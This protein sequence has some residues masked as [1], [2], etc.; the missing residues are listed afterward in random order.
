MNLFARLGLDGSGFIRGLASAKSAAG[1]FSSDLVGSWSKDI[2]SKLTGAFGFAAV[3][4]AIAAL[5]RQTI[6][7]TD[8]VGDLSDQL[9]MTTDDIQR[10]MIA[11]GRNG[12]EFEAIAK[13]ITH[14]GDARQKALAGDNKSQQMFA[15]YGVSMKQLADGQLANFELTKALYDSASKAGIGVQ[16]QADLFDLAGK[17]GARLAATFE[18]LKNLGPVKLLS[19]ENIKDL[20]AAQDA[21]DEL[22][23]R[24]MVAAAPVAGFGARVLGRMQAPP[25]SALETLPGIGLFQRFPRALVGELFGVGK[26]PSAP[27]TEEQIAAEKKRRGSLLVAPVTSGKLTTGGSQIDTSDSYS[28]IGLFVGG[29]GNPMV[30]ISRRQLS[31]SE[32]M[33]AELRLLRAANSRVRP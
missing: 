21:I 2:G 3:T 31:V 10:A 14:I 23:R 22:G 7:Y 33:L 26:K 24:S 29:A 18:T 15:R 13:A 27:L 28:K 19:A 9:D 20:S 32:H 1:K 11:G 30:D 16:E 25:V 5:G 17:K 6:A 8:H 4:G 12:I